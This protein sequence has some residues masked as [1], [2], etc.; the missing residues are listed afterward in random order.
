M[1]QYLLQWFYDGVKYY[2][3]KIL[4]YSKNQVYF[5]ESLKEIDNEE[6]NL[7]VEIP[8]PVGDHSNHSNISIYLNFI[9]TGELNRTFYESPNDNNDLFCNNIFDLLLFSHSVLCYSLEKECHKLIGK[10]KPRTEYISKLFKIG[11]TYDSLNMFFKWWNKIDISKDNSN[12]RMKVLKKLNI[13]GWLVILDH[14]NLNAKDI[15]LLEYVHL[16]I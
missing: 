1:H 12:K 9:Y 5:I 15:S 2:L 14:K 11:I 4:M 7:E 3:F 13:E 16:K 10:I 6:I 8:I